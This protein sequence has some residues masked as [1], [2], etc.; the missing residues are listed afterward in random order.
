MASDQN[1]LSIRSF[2]LMV[3]CLQST[4]TVINNQRPKA[5]NDRQLS[6]TDSRQQPT[7]V[8]DRQPSLRLLAVHMPTQAVHAASPFCPILSP[9]QGE[10][11]SWPANATQ[12]DSIECE[13]AFER[14]DNV[15]DAACS[16]S[17]VDAQGGAT[18]HVGEKRA[19]AAIREEHASGTPSKREQ[20]EDS[21]RP[22]REQL[23]KW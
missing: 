12:F 20:R 5:V 19:R 16:R 1:F 4:T 23:K 18:Y 14:L 22:A 3:R 7:D 10:S 9:R 13:L 17:N 21:T 11:F 15:E 2:P 6:T 8:K